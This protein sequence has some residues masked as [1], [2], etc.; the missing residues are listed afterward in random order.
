M[1]NCTW[2]GSQ[3]REREIEVRRRDGGIKCNEADRTEE[4]KCLMECK[5]G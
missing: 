4:R 3:H 1:G 2:L 5:G